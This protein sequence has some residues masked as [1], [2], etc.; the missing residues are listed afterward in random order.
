MELTITNAQFGDLREQL[1]EA[2]QNET[3]IMLDFQNTVQLDSQGV[4]LLIEAHLELAKRGGSLC[5]RN[6][7]SELQQ[8]FAFL[9][10]PAMGTSQLN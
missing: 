7:S 8:M 9:G 10:L 3:Q 4:A 6:L 2:A 5:F 1:L